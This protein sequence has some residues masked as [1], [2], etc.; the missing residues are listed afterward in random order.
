MTCTICK[1]L[2][3]SFGHKPD[4]K[5]CNIGSNFSGV[6]NLTGDAD[7]RCDS[8]VDLEVMANRALCTGKYTKQLADSC[9][10]NAEQVTHINELKAQMQRLTEFLA[11]NSQQGVLHLTGSGATYPQ[12]PGGGVALQGSEVHQDNHLI[13]AL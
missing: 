4:G 1:G 11:G 8:T 9:E 5:G 2:L 7:T 12:D 13:W 3:N 10:K 6:S